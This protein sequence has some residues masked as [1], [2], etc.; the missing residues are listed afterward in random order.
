MSS[1]TLTPPLT[2]RTFLL[3]DAEPAD[4]A[5]VLARELSQHDVAR[6]ALRGL[7]R[8]SGSALQ[9]VHGEIARVAAGLL[10]LDLGDALVSG[11]R[12][13][14]AMTK[15]ARRT[16]VVPGSEAVV[17]LATHRVTWPYEAH[18]DVLVDGKKIASFDLEMT[19]V[20]DLHG[21]VA[22]LRL[23]DLV[24]LRGGE[25]TITATLTLEGA[26]LARQQRRMDAALVVSLDP[27]VPMFGDA[28]IANAPLRHRNAPT[29]LPT[30]RL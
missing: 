10:D 6:S 24:A 1:A 25:C 16:L 12:K 27:P 17:V 4:T 22:V 3:G 2:A 23:G 7:T 20:F 8:L 15:A 13:Y 21:V 30:P 5:A 14:V 29:S 11:W 28:A 9:A 19:V 18:I 26:T